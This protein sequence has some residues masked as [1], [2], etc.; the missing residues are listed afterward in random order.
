MDQSQLEGILT[1]I[2][3]VLEMIG[4]DTA[5]YLAVGAFYIG[6]ARIFIKPLWAAFEEFA[7][8][9]KTDKDD[10]WLEKVKS[11]KNILFFVIDW[12]TSIKFKK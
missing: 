1:L 8:E 6:L 7:K 11:P 10:K 12:F 4:G 5:K 2:K 3:P 9:T